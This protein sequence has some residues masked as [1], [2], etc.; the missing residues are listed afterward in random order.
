MVVAVAAAVRIRGA[1]NELWLDEI[2]SW[3]LAGK[4]SRP[5]EIFTKIHMDNNHYLNTLYLYLIGPRRSWLQ[6]RMLSVVAGVGT[7]ALAGLIGRRRNTASGLLA[8][9]LTASSYVLIL[10]ASEARGYATAVFFSFLSFYL[11]D[12]YLET[13]RWPLAL[14]FSL[15]AVLGFLSHMVFLGFYAAALV[16]S[17][18]RLMKSRT[19][20]KQIVIAACACHAVPI[21]FFAALYLVS[22]RY[23]ITGG[24]TASTLLGVYVDALAW[25]LGTPISHTAIFAT[26]RRRG[27]DTDRR[28]VDA[29]A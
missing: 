29:L 13:R 15:S 23:V 16:W 4:I 3:Y 24:G 7:V 11:L 8:M 12:R 27:G 14:M 22:L 5:M 1:C 21:L 28:A 10:Y 25:A 19:G 18:Y 20:P 2:W 26:C 9:L 17:G 6:Y